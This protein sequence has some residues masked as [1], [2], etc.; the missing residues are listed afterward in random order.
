[1]QQSPI[2]LIYIGGYG[3]SG[4]SV[5]DRLV[6]ER[7]GGLSGGELCNLFAWADDDQPC[8][9]GALVTACSLWGPVLSAVSLE[10][11]SSFGELRAMND[12][13]EFHDRDL[14]TWRAVWE[15]VFRQLAA[16]GV[17]VIIDSSKSARGR[18]RLDHLNELGAVDV[19]LFV[20]LYRRLPAVMHSRRRGNNVRMERG[21][22][23]GSPAVASLRAAV[24]WWRANRAARRFA[25]GPVPYFPL[26]Y[27]RLV[28]D[29]DE[30]CVAIAKQSLGHTDTVPAAAL[31][32]TIAGNRLLRQNWDGS[33]RADESW[34]TELPTVLRSLASGVE[35]SAARLG[36]VPR[37]D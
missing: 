4:S 29:P 6:A 14:V 11:G 17:R 26:D 22:P 18:H 16:A 1:M 32:H 37:G 35:W 28:I 34:R 31:S 15:L 10:T 21:E 24:G 25:T 9:C 19:R 27:D 36:V 8:S 5:L 30:A 3:R 13:A 7:V 2:P 12:A 33:V 20:H 23:S